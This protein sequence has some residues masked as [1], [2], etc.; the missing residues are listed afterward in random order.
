MNPLRFR[1]DPFLAGNKHVCEAQDQSIDCVIK[2]MVVMFYENAFFNSTV[3]QAMRPGGLELTKEILKII[4]P[5]PNWSILDVACGLGATLQLLTE[6]FKCQTYGLDL[7]AKIL[8][9][10]RASF[11]RGEDTR[12]TEFIC[13]DSEF[14]PLREELFDAVVCECSLSLFPNK[15]RALSEMVRTLKAG[16]K[17]VLTDVTIKDQAVKDTNGAIGWCMCVAGAETLEGYISLLEGSGVKVLY[18]RDASEVYE[19][20]TADPEQRRLLE[21][22]IGY[23]VMIGVKA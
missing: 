22:K 12:F 14:L 6:Q 19:W 7:S 9:K 15:Q 4:N 18:Y 23:G 8:K 13:A 16:G 3:W 20:G 1:G 5:K 11:L 10:A 17:L 21:G 2:K